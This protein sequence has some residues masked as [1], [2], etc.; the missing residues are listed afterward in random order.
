MA[1]I[2]LLA[3]GKHMFPNLL[4]YKNSMQSCTIQSLQEFMMSQSQQIQC[5][6]ANLTKYCVFVGACF[7]CSFSRIPFD[8]FF[9]MNYSFDF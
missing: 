5:I 4:N 9:L 2:L 8:F 1:S 7:I 6:L 3:V